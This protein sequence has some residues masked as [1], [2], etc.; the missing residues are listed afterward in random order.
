MQVTVKYNFFLHAKTLF[1]LT[2][3]FFICLTTVAIGK[4]CSGTYF[5]SGTAYSTNNTILKIATLTVKFGKETKTVL[6]D[7]NG[8]FEIE[9]AWTNACQSGR[10]KK[11][12]KQDNKK[13]NP[14]YVYI[15]YATNEIKLENKWE[16][17][18]DCFPDS[19]DSVTW[20][21]DL[22]FSNG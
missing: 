9:L 7:S 14:Q 15:G 12:H 2:L 4:G 6:T 20:K 21:K 1:S 11:Q 16:N 8:H 5:I 22:Y 18:R 3:I 17:Y 19:K 10:T 13:I